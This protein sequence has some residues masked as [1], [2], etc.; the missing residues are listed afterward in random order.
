MRRGLFLVV[1]IL[2]LAALSVAQQVVVRSPNGSERLKKGDMVNI[3][4]GCV[5]CSGTTELHLVRVPTSPAATMPARE[6]YQEIGVIKASIPVTPTQQF[7][8][9]SWRIGD[10]Y[11]GKAALGG[12]YKILVKVVT[13]AK[14]VSDLSDS[15][16]VI[17]AV[18]TIDYFAIND[19]LAVTS[20]RKVTLNYRITGFPSP[21][22]FRVRCT[23]KP[24]TVKDAPLAAGT[25]PTYEL[26]AEPGDYTIELS[27]MNDFGTGPSKTDAI[28]YEALPTTQDYTVAASAIQCKGFSDLNPAWYSC[29]CT[30]YDIKPS[31]DNCFC[32]SW[33]AVG[34][35]TTGQVLGNKV[36][37]EFFG[38]RQLNPGWSFVSIDLSPFSCIPQTA[39]GEMK[40]LVMPQVGSRDI[41]FKVRLWIEG[42]GIS[43]NECWFWIKSL[44]IR[45]PVGRPVSEAFK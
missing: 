28:R 8:S 32:S 43:T 44:V 33:G 42:G 41:L 15:G 24:G 34:V 23:P 13:P 22:G 40:V 10:Y 29:R 9:Y 2:S 39:K 7:Y 17:G 26:P 36:E 4:W 25:W 12:G 1:G 19:G 31:P 30:Y 11:G 45:G 5:Q 14:T 3:E 6:G 18:P 16:F 38:G 35:K 20:Q 27:L 21:G 37:Y